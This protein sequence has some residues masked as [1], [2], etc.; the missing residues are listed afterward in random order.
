MEASVKAL[1]I[2]ILPLLLAITPAAANEKVNLVLNWVPTAD[3]A[4]Y[5]FARSQGWYEKAGIDLTIE[6]GKGS[7]IAAQRVGAGTSDLGIADLA[8]A[9]VA[10]S[11][12]ANV[13]AVMNV[14]AN[15]PQG[16]Y[17]LKS[18]GINGSK[19]FPGRK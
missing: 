6:I 8:T 12:G 11:K 17:W 13:V 16:F 19:D 7:G 10:K 14:Y 9:L 1:K 4:P 15:S 18:S 5:Y 3:H 2:A